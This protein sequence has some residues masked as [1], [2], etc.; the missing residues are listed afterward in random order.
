MALTPLR[1]IGMAIVGCLLM[2]VLVLELV[3][4]AAERRV[5]R[6]S[7]VVNA[8]AGVL[9]VDTVEARLAGVTSY[10]NTQAFLLAGRYRILQILDSAKR[11][12]GASRDTGAVRVFV[13]RGITPPLRVG[14]DGTMNRVKAAIASEPPKA[15]VDVFF[16]YD[17]AR[18]ERGVARTMIYG[19]ET[20]YELPSGPGQRCLVY[21]RLGNMNPD[22][23]LRDL[24]TQAAADQFLGPCA[25]YAAF[26]EPGPHIRDWL[27]AGAWR[28]TVD[29]SWTVETWRSSR[30]S[31]RETEI[32]T[33]ISPVLG[34]LRPQ[35]GAVQ[36]VKGNLELCDAAAHLFPEVR[37][38]A[39]AVGA[40][41][42]GLRVGSPTRWL[43]SGLGPRGA[44]FLADAVRTLGRERF[45][46]FWTSP[47]SLPVAFEKATGQPWGEWINGWM[48]EKYGTIRSG[49]GVSP[50]TFGTATLIVIL[51]VM[52]TLRFAVQRQY[53]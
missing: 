28:F 32:F 43:P 41:T 51:S 11:V 31:G 37:P 24:R 23:L 52:I 9:P 6:F 1:W 8:R 27:M 5:E 40:A 53:T 44:D 16:A 38:G 4:P 39:R 15:G 13:D 21:A 50:Y 10:W 20:R 19:V 7:P 14:I 18:F 3:S 12:M 47:D 35:S 34:W 29:G 45:Q 46:A 30:S 17:T 25:F 36:C 22:A 33:S 49:P 2:L 26:G 42:I 48:T